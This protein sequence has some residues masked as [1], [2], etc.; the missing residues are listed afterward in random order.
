ME[1]SLRGRQGL[2]GIVIHLR[3]LSNKPNVEEKLTKE[4]LYKDLEGNG[5]ILNTNNEHFILFESFCFD[6]LF[7]FFTK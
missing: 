5:R 3:Y 1:G 4:E 7:L 6:L 2:T